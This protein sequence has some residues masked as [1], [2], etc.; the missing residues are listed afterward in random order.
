MDR[1]NGYR[2]DMDMDIVKIWIEVM[3]IDR[4]ID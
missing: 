4:D 3:D 2:L 1:G